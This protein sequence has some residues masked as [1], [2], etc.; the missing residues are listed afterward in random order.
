MFIHE[1]LAEGDRWTRDILREGFARPGGG[2]GDLDRQVDAEAAV[3]K[4]TM[5]ARKYLAS[6]VRSEP[7]PENRMVYQSPPGAYRYRS[8]Q[9]AHVMAERVSWVYSLD[10][11][12][13]YAWIVPH[14]S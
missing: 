5:A 9:R 11:P 13:V 1:H 8:D 7:L 6:L 12:L 3:K 14:Q 2:S 10:Q 4:A